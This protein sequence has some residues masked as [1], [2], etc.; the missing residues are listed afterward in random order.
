MLTKLSLIEMRTHQV[1]FSGFQNHPIHVNLT[2]RLQV[3]VFCAQLSI[4]RLSSR[5]VTEVSPL[6]NWTSER[7][8]GVA[9]ENVVAFFEKN[10]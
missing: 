7:F 3:G 2:P 5:F 1:Y 9:V 10:Q 6:P 4:L 8:F